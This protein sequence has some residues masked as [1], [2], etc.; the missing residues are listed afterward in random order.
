[1]ASRMQAIKSI[2][3]KTMGPVVKPALEMG[4]NTTKKTPV[5]VMGAISPV[6]AEKAVAH[7]DPHPWGVTWPGHAD[8]WGKEEP[9]MIDW[10]EIT[11][12]L[13][14]WKSFDM[15]SP[16]E[17]FFGT[18]GMLSQVAASRMR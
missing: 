8:K 10:E 1:M 9:P 14:V 16:S 2:T 7:A 15:G 4:L 12:S 5:A 17:M 6:L 18:V 11:T 3:R 13:K